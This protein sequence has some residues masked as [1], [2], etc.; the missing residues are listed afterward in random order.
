MTYRFATTVLVLCSMFY[1]CKQKGKV[2]HKLHTERE[3]KAN[4]HWNRVDT[5]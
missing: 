5:F 4:S 3:C 1:E 2:D